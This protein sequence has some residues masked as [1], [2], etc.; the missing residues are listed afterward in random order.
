MICY[1]YRITA[2]F[3]PHELLNGGLKI[4]IIEWPSKGCDLNPIENIWANIVNSWTAQHEWMSNQLMYHTNAEW[5]AY[6]K[7]QDVLYTIIASVPN[8]LQDV[9][10][11]GGGW[12]HYWVPVYSQG[13]CFIMYN[14][15][16]N[17][18]CCFL[19]EFLSI[20]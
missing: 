14:S 6:R 4:N 18:K 13:Y 10:A 16:V 11:N 17:K 1:F 7:N 20:P 15:I 5:E 12:T 9:I 3:T 8:R 19:S 2:R